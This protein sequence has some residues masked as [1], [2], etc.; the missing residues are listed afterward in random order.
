MTLKTKILKKIEYYK[1]WKILLYEKAFEDGRRF[2]RHE[3]E[4]ELTVARI[5]RP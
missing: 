4:H 5:N 2:G 3:Y 1:R